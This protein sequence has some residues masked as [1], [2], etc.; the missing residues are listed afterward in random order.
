MVRQWEIF[1]ITLG[2]VHAVALR[3]TLKFCHC[4]ILRYTYSY[5]FCTP[6]LF[7]CLR[8]LYSPCSYISSSLFSPY[9][10][11]LY[12]WYILSYK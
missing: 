2:C 11:C 1:T 12:H 7:L 10:P 5:R 4:Q 9:F 3:S 8:L 6:S